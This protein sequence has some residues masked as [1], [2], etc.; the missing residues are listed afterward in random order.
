MIVVHRTSRAVFGDVL[1]VFD[2]VLF[3]SWTEEEVGQAE[4]GADSNL[5]GVFGQFV[6]IDNA[7][8]GDLHHAG[9]LV[10][11]ARFHPFF[12]DLFAFGQTQTGSF[13]SC[14]VDQDSL[15]SL[16]LQKATVLID[17]IVLD[18]FPVAKRKLIIEETRSR[19][20][21]ERRILTCPC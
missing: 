18:R 11:A 4:H 8:A 20:A 17:D 16:L 6:A 1:E 9:H 5:L 10:L 19:L 3:A 7:C 21:L 15:D 13:A 12:T 2:T 14:A